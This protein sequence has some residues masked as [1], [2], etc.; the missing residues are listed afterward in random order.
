MQSDAFGRHLLF[1]LTCCQKR[2]ITQREGLELS[3]FSECCSDWSIGPSR[4]VKN[5]TRHSEGPS[6]KGGPG[7]ATGEVG[8]GA[9]HEKSRSSSQI[10]PR[11]GVPT[12][13]PQRY[14]ALNV[15]SD[16]FCWHLLF[17]QQVPTKSVGLGV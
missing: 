1:G 3:T 14:F 8:F 9:G 2:R 15:Q 16:A 13:F 12:N 4:S 17:E 11:L 5:P 6:L 7:L 10:S